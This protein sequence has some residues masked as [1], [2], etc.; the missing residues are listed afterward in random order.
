MCGDKS[1]VNHFVIVYGCVC[2]MQRPF[3]FKHFILSD[4][5]RK[6]FF[7]FVNFICFLIQVLFVIC[8][9]L[10]SE[11]WVIRITSSKFICFWSWCRIKFTW[12]QSAF[13]K[14][15]FL[16]FKSENIQLDYEFIKIEAIFYYFRLPKVCH[17]SCDRC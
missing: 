4:T 5:E 2:C 15:T 17:L 3:Y 14:H 10:C 6:V 9:F 12:N 7:I 1:N 13:E 16:I 8:F 11:E